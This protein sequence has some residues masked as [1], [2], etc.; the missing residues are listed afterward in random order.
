M[1]VKNQYS[2]TPSPQNSFEHLRPQLHRAQNRQGSRLAQ[3][4]ERGIDHRD[5]YIGQALAIPRDRVA[6]RAALEKLVLAPRT[7][8]AGITLAAAFVGKKMR[9]PLKNIP[10]I[11]RIIEHHYSP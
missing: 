8:L 6:R 10:H 2:S 1:A 3:A 4:A 5:A 9:E 11:C 7:E